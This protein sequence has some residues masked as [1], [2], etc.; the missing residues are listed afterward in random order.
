MNNE[1]NGM[2]IPLVG[3]RPQPAQNA[4]PKWLLDRTFV[5]N[6]LM[7]A[8]SG[9]SAADIRAAPEEWVKAG[10]RLVDTIREEMPEQ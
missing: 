3:H 7:A 6:F 8:A 1:I 2:K 4:P 9:G 10:K 5:T